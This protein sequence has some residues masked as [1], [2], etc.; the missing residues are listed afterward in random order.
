MIGELKSMGFKVCLWMNPYLSIESERFAEARDSGFLLEAP[1]GEPCTP[2]LWGDF[3]PAV[4]IV[5]MTDPAAVAWFQGLLRPLLAMGVDVFK[6]DFGEGVPVDAVAHGGMT[7]DKLHNLYPLLYNDAVASVTA[8]ATERTGLVWARSSHAGGQ[9]HGAQWSGDPTCTFQSMASTLRGGLS[10]AFCGHAYWSHDMGGFHGTPDPELYVRWSQFGF[11][12]P[13]SRAHGRTSRLP[14]E[15]GGEALR[16]FRNFAR[17]RYR[18][19]PYLFT[20]AARSAEKGLPMMRPMVLEFPDDPLTHHVDLQYMLGEELLAAPIFNREAQRTVYIPAGRW[21]DFWTHETCEGP[22]MHTAPAPLDRMPLFVR[23]DALIPTTDEADHI[24]DAP[25]DPVVFDAYLFDCGTSELR[26]YD[27]A[28]VVSAWK[29]GPRLSITLEGAKPSVGFRL[30]ALPGAQPV[31]TVI[32]NENSI[33]YRKGIQVAKGKT[34]GWTMEKDGAVLALLR[35][36]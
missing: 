1:D 6:T 3:H 30:M 22:G 17:L 23:A 21:I 2:K 26:D 12:S 16:I 25:F 11:L 18:L 31:E 29:E 27:G 13:L 36:G 9:R 10:L 4:G 35:S 24:A 28:T 19:L 20:C 15:F 33:P 8:E 7:G 34:S 32:F 5:D 14:W